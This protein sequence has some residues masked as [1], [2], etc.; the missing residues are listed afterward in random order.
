MSKFFTLWLEA[1][2]QSWGSDSKFWRRDTLKFPTKSGIIGLLLCAMGETGAQKELLKK[3]STLKISVF[4]YLKTYA[5]DGILKKVKK[6]HLLRDYHVIGNG[7]KKDD[8]WHEMNSLKK[9]DGTSTSCGTKITQRFYL[10]NA[11]F[12]VIIET[13]NEISDRIEQSLKFPVYDIYL[14]RKNCVPT[15]FV[16]QGM[17]VS[18]E[19]AE[20]KL[21]QITS[22]KK[23]SLEFTV[24]EGNLPDKGDV[25]SLN[26]IPIQFGEEKKYSDRQVTII[27]NI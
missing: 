21:Q 15:D 13:S 5:K 26:D 1:P 23:L 27:T 6:T 25:I 8:V 11:K 16:F 12:G 14:G 4:S 10:Q 20:K 17:F 7:Y 9:L 18:H 3:M 22:E 2:L 19:D 24:I